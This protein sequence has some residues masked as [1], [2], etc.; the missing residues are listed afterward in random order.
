MLPHA[1]L[2]LVAT[3]ASVHQLA[4]ASGTG[5]GSSSANACPGD[6]TGTGANRAC[7]FTAKLDVFAARTGYYAFDECGATVQ[8]VLEMETGIE[9][10]FLQNDDSNWLHPLGFAYEPDGAHEGVD[11]LE[12]GIDRSADG[13][14]DCGPSNTC[15]APEYYFDGTFH[16]AVNPDTGEPE[17][18]VYP[19]S[20]NDGNFGL[21]IYEPRFAIS[22]GDWIA[23]RDGGTGLKNNVK[24]TITDVT[25]VA[26]IFYFCHIHNGMSGRIK[27]VTGEGSDAIQLQPTDSPAL[28]G[29][30]V[31]A[32]FDTACGTSGLDAYSG[33]KV[34]PAQDAN[35]FLCSA[36]NATAASKNFDECLHAMDCAMHTEMRISTHH[37]DPLTTFVHQMIPHHHNA[38]NMA[39]TVLKQNA[40]NSE[41]DPEG[42][43]ADLM[44]TIINEQNKQI[45]FME[46]YLTDANRPS[47]D[48][49]MCNESSAVPS[50][51]PTDGD[52]QTSTATT[53]ATSS[54]SSDDEVRGYAVWAGIVT[55]LL[56]GTWVALLFAVINRNSMVKAQSGSVTHT[57]I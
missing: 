26:D 12:A 41:N 16:G 15:Q 6:C 49:A 3:I 25:S 44:W 34:C 46:S 43:M 56:I 48:A 55:A 57:S 21:D 23:H 27:L 5:D 42:E 20:G 4:T 19:V 7:K 36:D 2:L 32:N 51:S 11:E 38:V 50:P 13:V 17:P 47:Y 40:L 22:R 14:K 37:E 29:H 1:R 52:S 54:H 30:N 33:D 39:K 18:V 35:K 31:N 53:S 8:P 28:Y 9:Y 24:L 45:T 10:T